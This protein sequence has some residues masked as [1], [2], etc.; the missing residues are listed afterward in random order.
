MWVLSATA[1]RTEWT[2]TK[3]RLGMPSPNHSRASGSNAIAGSGLNMA[4]SVD[5]RWVP[6]RVDTARVVNTTASAM[7]AV[8]PMSS[9]RIVVSVRSISGPRTVASH[10]AAA[11][12]LKAGNISGL[13]SQRHKVP[14]RPPG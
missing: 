8:Y 3:M 14:T 10:S 2:M 7:P 5:R 1:H 9:T 6:R 11:I 13:L 12:S 4:V